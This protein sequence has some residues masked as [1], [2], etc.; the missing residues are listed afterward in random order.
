[1]RIYELTASGSGVSSDGHYVLSGS[2]ATGWSAYA[3]TG[4]GTADDPYEQGTEVDAGTITLT[5]ADVDALSVDFTL[6]NKTTYLSTFV[7]N[8]FDSG[9]MFGGLAPFEQILAPIEPDAD[10]VLFAVNKI[11]DEAGNIA[12][13]SGFTDGENSYETLDID[14]TP[15]SKPDLMVERSEVVS[16][17]ITIGHWDVLNEY[18]GVEGLF[19][20]LDPIQPDTNGDNI[21]P[22]SVKVNGTT[23]S[24]VDADRDVFFVSKDVLTS[25]NV[26]EFG[27]TETSGNF[28]V[29]TTD[30]GYD[31]SQPDEQFFALA[32]AVY[33]SG[34]DAFLRLD[35]YVSDYALSEKDGLSQFGGTSFD[36][37]IDLSGSLF[38]ESSDDYSFIDNDTIFSSVSSYREDLNAIKW[39]GYSDVVYTDTANPLFSVDMSVADFASLVDSKGDL[40]DLGGTVSFDVARISESSILSSDDVV[41]GLDF[42]VNLIDLIAIPIDFTI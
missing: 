35:V 7:V 24:L 1:M 10:D 18:Q 42:S 41:T 30:V 22:A 23:A 3:V 4:A 28:E 2:D 33:T 21:N 38:S 19:F 29:Y 36:L 9:L 27:V 5:Q 20:E 11:T 8:A 16:G 15:A 26:I 12:F 14:I 37:T 32:P 39:S 34:T 13:T 17:E 25:S 31:A 40:V 6:S